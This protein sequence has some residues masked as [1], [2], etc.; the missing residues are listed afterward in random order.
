MWHLDATIFNENGITQYPVQVESSESWAGIIQ[1]KRAKDDY[2][3]NFMWYDHTFI[4][5]G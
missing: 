2:S 4:V 5:T 3:V 1:W